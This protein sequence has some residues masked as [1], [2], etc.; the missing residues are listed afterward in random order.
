MCFQTGKAEHDLSKTRGTIYTGTELLMRRG[1]LM[2]AIM[3]FRIIDA[4]VSTGQLYKTLAE[5]R[6]CHM[7]S[8]SLQVGADFV[9]STLFIFTCAKYVVDLPSK[10]RGCGTSHS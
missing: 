8:N 7:Y 3:K 5:K 1:M 6:K 10:G 9:N 4:V 2:H